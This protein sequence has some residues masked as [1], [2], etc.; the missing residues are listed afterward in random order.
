M[1]EIIT[2]NSNLHQSIKQKISELK[3]RVNEAEKN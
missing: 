2:Q 1:N 3:D